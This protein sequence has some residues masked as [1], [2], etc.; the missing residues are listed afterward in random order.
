MGFCSQ[1][2]RDAAPQ[3]LFIKDI[4]RDRY[5]YQEMRSDLKV[6]PEKKAYYQD[7]VTKHI[8]ERLHNSKAT[9]NHAESQKETVIFQD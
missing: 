3:D 5:K 9:F 6:R 7:L 1:A 2:C 4:S 8:N